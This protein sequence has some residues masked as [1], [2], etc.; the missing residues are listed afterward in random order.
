MYDT[1]CWLHASGQR[2]DVHLV[3][4]RDV[5][6]GEAERQ[7]HGVR[8]GAEVQPVAG[9]DER[10]GHDGHR[11]ARHPQTTNGEGPEG[12]SPSSGESIHPGQRFFW[13]SAH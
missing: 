12:T 6:L 10:A 9:A 13:I 1:T 3:L 8:A 7:L 11:Q 2:L 5:T 4:E